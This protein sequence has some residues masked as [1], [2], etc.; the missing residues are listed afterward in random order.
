MYQKSFLKILS[1][2]NVNI[3]TKDNFN[4][5]DKQQNN[6]FIFTQYVEVCFNGYNRDGDGIESSC[7][8]HLKVLIKPP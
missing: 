4:P 6:S 1:H 7:Q 3:V 8:E 5:N 2:H